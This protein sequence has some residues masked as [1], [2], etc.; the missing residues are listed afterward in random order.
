MFEIVFVDI[1]VG[2]EV[3]ALMRR[4][5]V[6]EV[7]DVGPFETPLAEAPA[8]IDS[9]EPRVRAEFDGTSLPSI[10]SVRMHFRRSAG[11]DFVGF[12]EEKVQIFCRGSLE[13]TRH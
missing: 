8:N 11:G 5:W 12:V 2:S 9:R 10:A 13:K 3:P 6:A 1:E 4:I 7:S